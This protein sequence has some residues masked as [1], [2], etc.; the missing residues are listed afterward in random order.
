MVIGLLRVRLRLHEAASLKEKRSVLKPLMAR[1]RKDHNVAVAEVDDQDI[2]RSVV[3][4][5]VA[6][7]AGRD[8]VENILRGVAKDLGEHALFDLVEEQIE[9]I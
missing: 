2:W 1:L 4:A 3:L 5:I 9:L 7:S 8:P 6:V